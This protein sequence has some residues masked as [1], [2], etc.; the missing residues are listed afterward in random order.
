MNSGSKLLIQVP[1]DFNLV[2]LAVVDQLH[3]DE[4]WFCPPKHISYFS[5]NGLKNFAEEIGFKFRDI[6]TTFP[7]DMF[8]LCG[9]NYRDDPALGRIA[10]QMRL[11]FEQNFVATHGIGRLIDVYKNFCRAGIGRE[12]IILLECP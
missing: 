11:L 7:V 1:N 4:W 6:L 3:I 2:Q 5:P 8:L 12:V 10:H 9:L